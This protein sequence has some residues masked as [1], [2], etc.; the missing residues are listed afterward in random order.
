MP[1]LGTRIPGIFACRHTNSDKQDY[2]AAMDSFLEK[3]DDIR[4]MVATDAICGWTS[5][6]F[7]T[8]RSTCAVCR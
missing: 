1:Q 4:P 3:Y 6:T 7:A 5:K 2:K 8:A